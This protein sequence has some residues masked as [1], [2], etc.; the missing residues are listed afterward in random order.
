MKTRIK[1]VDYT[2]MNLKELEQEHT[3]ENQILFD[4]II[5]GKYT[6]QNIKFQKSL[7]D[8]L[9]KMISKRHIKISKIKG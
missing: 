2:T 9:Y 6:E 8:S 7:V 4:M 5:S 3:K 1:V